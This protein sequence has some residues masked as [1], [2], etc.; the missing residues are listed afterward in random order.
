MIVTELL[1]RI[2][3]AQKSSAVT[4]LFLF[5]VYFN[6][7][8]RNQRCWNIETVSSQMMPSPNIRRNWFMND[9]EMF[10]GRMSGRSRRV[11]DVHTRSQT[12]TDICWLLLARPF[13]HVS[14]WIF[15]L[16]FLHNEMLT[17]WHVWFKWLWHTLI[18]LAQKCDL[19]R[20][21]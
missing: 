9:N 4:L 7:S 2:M 5:V 14:M 16:R 1:T 8:A 20:T 19:R 17:L 18:S 13:I 11:T 12:R 15:Y 10:C 6:Y 3:N 21:H